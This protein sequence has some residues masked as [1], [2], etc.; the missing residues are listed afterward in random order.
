MFPIDFPY[1]VLKDRA[2]PGEWVA[3]PFCGRGT[4]NYAS[5]IL[6]LPSIGID[7][8]PVA[9]AISQAKLANTTPNAIVRAA[10]GILEKIKQPNEIPTGEFWDWAFHQEVLGVL[11]RLRDGLLQDCRSHSRKALRA[12]ILGALHGP[13]NKT[14][15]SYFS[16]QS[17]R[18]YAPKPKYSIKYWKGLGLKPESVNVLEI[19]TTRA[20]RYYSQEPEA[21]GK[22]IQG[23]SRNKDSYSSFSQEINWVITSPPYYGMNTY[24]PDQWLRMWFLGG[25]AKVD[26]AS[27]GQLSHAS[28]E[29]FALE[30]NQVWKNTGAACAPNAR[31]IIRFGGI[32]GRKTDPLKILCYSLQDTGWVINK[33]ESAGLATNG[34][35]QA[36]H[37]RKSIKAPREEYD[38]WA[39]WRG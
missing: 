16:N 4:T 34:K 31:L 12:I 8:S 26:Y 5:R 13:R 22:I 27:N 15:H 18:T 1:W 24:I 2:A 10:E 36:E 7:S 39:T 37:I 9:V 35:R 19:I 33:I 21:T 11:C 30:M 6:G 28:P 14:R 20:E 25:K 3:D 29:K 32:N 17:Q 23:D 38:I